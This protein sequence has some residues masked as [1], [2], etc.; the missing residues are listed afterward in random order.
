KGCD[1]SFYNRRFRRI[2]KQRLQLGQEPLLLP[3]VVND[4]EICDYKLR[5]MPLP[6]EATNE[7]RKTHRQWL[8]YYCK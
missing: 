8:D 6:D 2:N 5:F 1:S 7:H 3:E 4:Y